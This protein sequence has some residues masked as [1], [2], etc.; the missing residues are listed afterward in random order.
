MNESDRLIGVQKRDRGDDDTDVSRKRDLPA[1]QGDAP[2]A[3][4]WT[5]WGFWNHQIL[6]HFADYS[7][8]RNYSALLLAVS[9]TVEKRLVPVLWELAQRSVSTGRDVLYGDLL[10]HEFLLLEWLMS[11]FPELIRSPKRYEDPL[12]FELMRHFGMQDSNPTI[13]LP[14]TEGLVAVRETNRSAH[15]MRDADVPDLSRI[16][17]DHTFQTTIAQTTPHLTAQIRLAEAKIAYAI[18]RGSPVRPGPDARVVY[19]L[20]T[21]YDAIVGSLVLMLFPSDL[22][23]SEHAGLLMQIWLEVDRGVQYLTQ[24]GQYLQ[25]GIPP[26]YGKQ[27]K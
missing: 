17:P 12:R 26:V 1:S 13:L 16:S 8:T 22:P 10:L 27:R 9:S 5:Q 3:S 20:L 23:P 18:A 15:F 14:L 7:V 19:E 4:L 25:T 11:P 24:I 6:R 21:K 2:A